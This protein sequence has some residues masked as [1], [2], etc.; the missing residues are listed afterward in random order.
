MLLA[1][2]TATAAVTVALYDG[3]ALVARFSDV[4]ALRHGELLAPAIADVLEA[5]Q[6]APD[7]LTQVAVGVGP[8][9]FTGLRVGLVTAR[10]MAMVLDIPVVGV[11]SL[12]V[13][14]A[15][16]NAASA[17]GVATDARRKEVYWARYD[18]AGR[19][20]T[21]PA[22]VSPAALASPGPVLGPVA[23]LGAVLYPDAFQEAVRP[24][25]PDAA[26]L[27]RIV[28]E[29]TAELLPPEPLYLRRPDIAEPS[30]RKPVL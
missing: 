12:D 30:P 5:A 23:G 25:Y 26:D 24:E 16:V 22:V 4:G 19:R 20:I 1:L 29:G 10:T 28:A 15:G 27:A 2:D 21:E 18:P 14:A 7:D 9:P 3:T 8:G 11:C 6:A 13:V 17:F